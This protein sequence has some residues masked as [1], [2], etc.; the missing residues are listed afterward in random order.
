MIGSALI[1][2]GLLYSQIPGVWA[3]IVQRH[4]GFGISDF[5]TTGLDPAEDGSDKIKGMFEVD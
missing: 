2:V 4:G 3:Q 1:A 5:L